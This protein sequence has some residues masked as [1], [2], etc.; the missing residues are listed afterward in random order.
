MILFSTNCVVVLCALFCVLVWVGFFHMYDV[1]IGE[2]IKNNSRSNEKK[3]AVSAAL[4]ERKA[5]YAAIIKPT[6]V[7]VLNKN[8]ASYVPRNRTV[9]KSSEV[10]RLYTDQENTLS[11]ASIVWA[12]FVTLPKAI[13][14]SKQLSLEPK[15]LQS[16]KLCSNDIVA[17]LT[18]KLDGKDL[19]WCRWS[20][21]DKGGRVKVSFCCD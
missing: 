21:S 15:I 2:Q 3:G 9:F 12:D 4:D 19:E 5:V 1:R 18:R 13:L 17:N 6:N 14:R 10:E 8:I 16:F 20:L 11:L 7:E